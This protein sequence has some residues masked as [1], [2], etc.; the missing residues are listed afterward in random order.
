MNNT[1]TSTASEQSVYATLYPELLATFTGS[2]LADIVLYPLETILHRLC[3]QGTRTIIDN[4]DNGLGVIPIITRYEGALDCFRSIITEEGIS[5]F[6]K[7]FGALI[8]Q[9]GLHV[10]ILRLAKFVFDTLSNRD[11][12][13]PLLASELAEMHQ[14]LNTTRG[15]GDIGEDMSLSFRLGSSHATSTPYDTPVTSMRSSQ[16]QP[17]HTGTGS[18][19]LS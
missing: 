5:G 10:I 9:Y 8:L 7:G 19:R 12:S 15:Q 18:A 1:S 14:Q 17:G 11:N 3:M 16:R 4:T 6:Y 2:L 13:R